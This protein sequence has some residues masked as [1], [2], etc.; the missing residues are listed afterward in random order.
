MS[1][2]LASNHRTKRFPF[3]PSKSMLHKADEK[4]LLLNPDERK[5]IYCMDVERGKVVD[6]WDTDGYSLSTIL[7]ET[8][9]SQTQGSDC[10]VGINNAGFFVVDPRANKKIVRTHQ[11]NNAKGTQFKCAATTMDGDLAIGTGLGEIRLFDH[12]TVAKSGGAIGSGPRAKTRLVG[13]G[14]PMK[15]VDVTRDGKYLLATCDS[16]LILSPL[17]DE[18]GSHTGFKKS[19][20]RAPLLLQL[21][22]E[23][24]VRVGGKVCFTPAKFNIVGEETKIVTSTANWMIVWNLEKLVHNDE[25]EVVITYQMKWFSDAVIADDFTSHAEGEIVLTMPDDV[26]VYHCK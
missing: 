19:V 6:E 22:S 23:D 20:K 15:A 4:L 11:Y 16:Y 1:L 14:D 2:R 26:A 24:I 21:S 12:A 25:A 9:D 7:P 17:M 13:F 18:T 5:K 3:S 10:F 8:K